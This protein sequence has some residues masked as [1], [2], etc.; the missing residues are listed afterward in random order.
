MGS[1]TSEDKMKNSKRL[2]P[3]ST[4]RTTGNNGG[5]NVVGFRELKSGLYRV[6]KNAYD[7]EGYYQAHNSTDVDWDWDRIEQE[8]QAGQDLAKAGVLCSVEI[9]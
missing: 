1:N 6:N 7:S 2:T 3:N 9:Y 8:I 4:V 5:F